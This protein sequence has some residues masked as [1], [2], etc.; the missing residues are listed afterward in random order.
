MQSEM[1]NKSNQPF[2]KMEEAELE[3]VFFDENDVVVTSGCESD[4]CN[5][6]TGDCLA[7]G[8]IITMADG[9]YKE[10]EDIRE[11]DYVLS[12]NHETGCYAASPILYAYR[13]EEPK[14]AFTLK[15]ANGA[16]LSI[17]GEHDLFEQESCKYVTITEDSAGEFVGKHFYSVADKSYVEL[18]K[19]VY[20][21]EKT[22]Y[23]ELYAEKTLNI[24]ANGMLNA[25]DDVDYLLNIYEF[26]EDLGADMKA[27]E[28][29]IQQYGLVT[30]SEIYNFA[31]H[32]YDAWNM[33][34]INISV[35]KGLTSME[36]LWNQH[37]EYLDQT[38]FIS[39]LE[40]A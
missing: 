26:N 15:F 34:Y 36:A 6:V 18:T 37:T 13:S 39:K 21:T 32:E 17:V 1:T 19:V 25:A 2:N 27:L 30:F 11:G 7:K 12:F 24:V 10:I 22:D 28:R 33:R 35:G 40:C 8:T 16:T 9:S 14:C 31:Q 29:D 38:G 5:C 4:T 20:E 3:V 23:Y